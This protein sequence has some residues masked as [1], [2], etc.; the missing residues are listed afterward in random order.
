MNSTLMRVPLMHG[1][2][3]RT[4]GFVTIHSF[5]AHL[6]WKRSVEPFR[7]PG[8]SISFL[9]A[10]RR[11][12]S[13]IKTTAGL[14]DSRERAIVSGAA[15]PG[16]AD[17]LGHAAPPVGKQHGVEQPISGRLHRLVLSSA[18]TKSRPLHR[19]SM[20]A[21]AG[22]RAAHFRLASS[23]G[24][25]L[26]GLHRWPFITL[27]PPAQRDEHE[28]EDEGGGEGDFNAAAAQRDRDPVRRQDFVA[29]SDGAGRFGDGE[30][31]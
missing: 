3:P 30:A 15:W 22:R 2:P 7:K 18:Y 9:S 13:T 27:S 11:S 19:V 23:P 10:A 8:L 20:A 6:L 5:I 25:V 29:Y 24:L 28:L 31:R 14:R 12:S 21:S 1:L 17:E 26:P 16:C 4:P